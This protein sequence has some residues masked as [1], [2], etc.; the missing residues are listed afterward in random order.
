[1]AGC[2]IQL[3]N[4][5]FIG[6]AVPAVDGTVQITDG[7]VRDDSA[8]TQDIPD[9]AGCPSP[10][11]L[12][13][14]RASVCQNV[15]SRKRA[16]VGVGKLLVVLYIPFEAPSLVTGEGAGLLRRIC[17]MVNGGHLVCETPRT[18]PSSRDSLLDHDGLALGLQSQI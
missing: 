16:L 3:R 14:N 13:P 7:C 12:P 18:V 6:M 9:D 8:T 4:S 17:L 5:V 15:Y 2:W 10:S 11:P 1:M